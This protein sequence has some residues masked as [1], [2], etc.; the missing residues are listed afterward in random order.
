[1]VVHW[2]PKAARFLVLTADAGRVRGVGDSNRLGVLMLRMV[3]LCVN[4]LVF[5]EVLGT[6]EGFL[7][8]LADMRFEGCVDCMVRERG[9]GEE[10]EREIGKTGSAPRR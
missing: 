5:L 8:D 10:G 7:A 6:L 2:G 3:L 9:A 1:M 4:L